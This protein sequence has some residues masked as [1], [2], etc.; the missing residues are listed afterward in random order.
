MPE[1]I[2][3]KHFSERAFDDQGHRR[4]KPTKSLVV[5]QQKWF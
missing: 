3:L 2:D 5:Y 4:Q 1:I